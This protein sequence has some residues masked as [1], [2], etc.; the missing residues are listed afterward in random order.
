MKKLAL[1]ATLATFLIV[2]PA[3]QAQV[4]SGQRLENRGQRFINQAHRPEHRGRYY[5]ARGSGRWGN[6]HYRRPYGR[7]AEGHSRSPYGRWAQ[8]NYHSP[9]GPANSKVGDRTYNRSSQPAAGTW[10]SASNSSSPPAA[11]TSTRSGDRT[12]NHTTPINY[13]KE[14]STSASPASDSV[15]N[16]SAAS[17]ATTNP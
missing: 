17:T 11:S 12:Y 2:V 14:G 1:L 3:V 15:T 16:G 7:W 6:N 13:K 5:Q 10:G 8:G 9:Y 4:R